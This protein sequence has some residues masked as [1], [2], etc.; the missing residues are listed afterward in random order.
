MKKIKILI[1]IISIF[2]KIYCLDNGLGRT[3][4]MGLSTKTKFN[5]IVNEE[6]IKDY[7]DEIYSSGLI[8]AGYKYL[9][10]DDCCNLEEMEM[11]K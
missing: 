3:P 10:I 7:I 5:C 8:E 1:F 2:T 9:I 6:V 11:E 4:Q